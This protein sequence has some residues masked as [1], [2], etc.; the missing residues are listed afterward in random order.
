MFE[1]FRAK[2]DFYFKSPAESNP[3]NFDEELVLGRIINFQKRLAEIK[4]CDDS[5][6]KIQSSNFARIDKLSRVIS[7]K[8][9][10]A[11]ARNIYSG[12]NFM[13][14]FLKK[15]I[16]MYNKFFKIQKIYNFLYIFL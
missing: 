6:L 5:F 7:N 2:L 15:Y 11:D 9:V 13:N 1:M 10:L 16:F 4:V 12:S 3:W 14:H 8:C